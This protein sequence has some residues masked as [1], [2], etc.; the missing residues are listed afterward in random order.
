M[1]RFSGNPRFSG[2]ALRY[3]T[4]CE[5]NGHRLH[6]RTLGCVTMRYSRMPKE[7]SRMHEAAHRARSRANAATNTDT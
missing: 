2:D 7:Q 6:K 5:G 4:Q 3:D 1:P